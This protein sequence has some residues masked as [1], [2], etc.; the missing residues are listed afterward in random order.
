MIVLRLSTNALR[1]T[2][3]A[4]F[5][6]CRERLITGPAQHQQRFYA[7]SVRACNGLVGP[8]RPAIRAD[9]GIRIP[10]APALRQ[11]RSDHDVGHSIRSH[12]RGGLAFRLVSHI[13]ALHPGTEA[14]PCTETLPRE[15]NGPAGGDGCRQGIEGGAGRA[16]RCA[17]RTAGNRPHPRVNAQP[18]RPRSHPPNPAARF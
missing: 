4:G 12:C 18:G 10:G 6:E 17:S 16:D 5:T 13:V 2:G 1:I 3:S 15:G 8:R 11:G 9:I 7:G 14:A